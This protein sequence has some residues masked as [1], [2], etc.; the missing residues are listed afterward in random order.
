MYLL[1]W[2]PWY[3]SV[4]NFK[5]NLP[6]ENLRG[7]AASQNAGIS[8]CFFGFFFFFLF[9]TAWNFKALSQM[10]EYLQICSVV[11]R[12]LGTFQMSLVINSKWSIVTR[13]GFRISW[14]CHKTWNSW[15]FPTLSGMLEFL[16]VCFVCG[17]FLGPIWNC[18][19]SA[20]RFT[21]LRIKKKK[22]CFYALSQWLEFMTR[23]LP[24]TRVWN[25]G[26]S[27][28]SLYWDAG[29]FKALPEMKDFM[30]SYMLLLEV[31]SGKS[32]VCPKWGNY[33]SVNFKYPEVLT[34]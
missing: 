21:V 26:L 25:S 2:W 1:K 10:M 34:N 8:V 12:E 33:G 24:V 30:T 28:S 6:V 23:V 15:D 32:W 9:T 5:V 3:G 27:V 31:E 16:P 18:G 13:S 17:I 14:L 11:L 29:C 22:Q 7:L 20:Y 19:I 4:P